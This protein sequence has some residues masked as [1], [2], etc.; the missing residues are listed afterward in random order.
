MSVCDG[1]DHGQVDMEGNN[2]LGQHYRPDK[3][4]IT[5][6]MDNISQ[7][8]EEGENREIELIESPVEETQ[9]T[10]SIDFS[11][12]HDNPVVKT[13]EK[14]FKPYKRVEL[15]LA[16]KVKVINA[17]ATGQSQRQL[18]KQ[19]GISKTQ[20]QCLLKR[21]EE[22]L[23]CYKEGL[24]TWRKRTK[25][26]RNSFEEVSDMVWQWYKAE[27]ELTNEPVTGPMIQA[28]AMAVTQELGLYDEFKA[29]NGWLEGFKRRY[30]L[31]RKRKRDA[32]FEQQ[33]VTMVHMDSD[34]RLSPDQEHPGGHSFTMD[35]P[36]MHPEIGQNESQIHDAY[37][38]QCCPTVHPVQPIPVF[39]QYGGPLHKTSPLPQ[40][41]S[42]PIAPRHVL[43]QG[44]NQPSRSVAKLQI[45]TFCE[46]L[47]FTSALKEFAVDKGSVTLIGLMTAMEHELQREKKNSPTDNDHILPDED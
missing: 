41:P 19:F 3:E 20:V 34:P 6:Q 1:P 21:K 27:C 30:G 18:A 47:R 10:F 35:R 8:K 29:S 17:S 24:A 16:D 39:T 25:G 44:N 5:I 32:S 28:K 36:T 7:N 33:A 38:I 37:S 11:T 26:R 40:R 42:V 43:S 4:I 15:C 14:T 22:I 31:F 23:Q 13:E 12:A 2:D 45:K 9:Q 46:A